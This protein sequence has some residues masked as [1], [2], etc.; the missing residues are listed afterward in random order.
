MFSIL[1]VLLSDK[2]DHTGN[3]ININCIVKYGLSTGICMRYINSLTMVQSGM[4]GIPIRIKLKYPSSD[5]I[6]M[7]RMRM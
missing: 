5:A 3:S 4:N 7:K 6:I 1:P 2:R